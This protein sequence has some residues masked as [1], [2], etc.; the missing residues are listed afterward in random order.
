[1]CDGIYEIIF[2]F[3]EKVNDLGKRLVRMVEVVFVLCVVVV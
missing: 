1:M 3:M 2:L